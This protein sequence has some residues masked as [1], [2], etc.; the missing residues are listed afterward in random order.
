M[1]NSKALSRTV[2]VMGPAWLSIS[3]AD[4]G[5]V[6]I[7]PNE[8]FR[9]KAQN[10]PGIRT[11]PPPSEPRVAGTMRAAT[12]IAEPELEPPLVSCGFHGLRPLPNTREVLAPVQPN[13]VVA[14][15]PRMIAPAVLRRRMIGAS[16]V[17]T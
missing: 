6:G 4:Q 11:E 17:G 9:A 10:A 1:S 5:Q 14:V 2:R 13:S 7:R 8:P 15:L 3:V 16:W 12:A